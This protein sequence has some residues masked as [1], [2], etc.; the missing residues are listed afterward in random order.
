MQGEGC[1][2]I[3]NDMQYRGHQSACQV[4]QYSGCTA[5]YHV[6]TDM[7]ILLYMYLYLAHYKIGQCSTMKKILTF[8]YFVHPADLTIKNHTEIF[9]FYEAEK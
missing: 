9:T 6:M 3:H 1:P 7:L 5:M 8:L 2:V 4:M